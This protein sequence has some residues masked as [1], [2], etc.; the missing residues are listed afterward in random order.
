[1][2]LH[3]KHVLLNES[4]FTKNFFTTSDFSTNLFLDR[5]DN[6]KISLQLLYKSIFDRHK[7]SW[8]NNIFDNTVVHEKKENPSYVERKNHF[9]GSVSCVGGRT[10]CLSQTVRHGGSSIDLGVA[11]MAIRVV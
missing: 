11:A 2:N 1:M 5:D 6:S 10:L 4:L 7:N 8:V 3:M 9:Q